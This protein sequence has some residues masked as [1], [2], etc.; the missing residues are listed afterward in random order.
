MRDYRIKYIMTTAYHLQAN[1]KIE[2][3]NKE[4]KEYLRKFIF[5][6]MEDWPNHLPQAEYSY[7]TRPRKG[8]TF[9]P[10]QVVFGEIPEVSAKKLIQK[11][12]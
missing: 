2:R 1:G 11:I 6:G 10:Y 7:N 5:Y 9:I 3:A 12:N 4:V 8:N